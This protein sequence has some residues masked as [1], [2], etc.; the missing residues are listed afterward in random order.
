MPRGGR[1]PG[2]GRPSGSTMP[3]LTRL[4]IGAECERRERLRREQRA[5]AAHHEKT[6]NLRRQYEKAQSIP[7]EDR[8]VWL[9][10][11]EGEDHLAEVDIALRRDQGL[12]R[13]V[14][15]DA[16]GED[17]LGPEPDRVYS[18]RLRQPK[19]AREQIVREV[20]RE[21]SARRGI[22]IKESAV[23]RYWTEFRKVQ[24]DLDQDL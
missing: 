16:V 11:E 22:E 14:D 19:G 4:A 18:Y 24:R 2:A 20:A 8:K 9:R 17:D 7:P 21:E 15:D 23:R 13:E 10:S 3:R 1:R 12:L 5:Q 6:E